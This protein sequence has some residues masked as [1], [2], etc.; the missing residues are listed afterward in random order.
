MNRRQWRDIMSRILRGSLICLLVLAGLFPWVSGN[1]M[2]YAAPAEYHSIWDT[3]APT[4]V[5]TLD[6]TQWRTGIGETYKGLVSQLVDRDA[7]VIGYRIGTSRRFFGVLTFYQAK[8]RH[9]DGSEIIGPADGP[10]NLITVNSIRCWPITILCFVLASVVGFQGRRTQR[11]PSGSQP[12]SV[13]TTE[14]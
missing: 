10:I 12:V 1:L 2:K 8:Y 9:K 6:W 11:S 7:E 3:G 5:A 4:C 13:N 14:F